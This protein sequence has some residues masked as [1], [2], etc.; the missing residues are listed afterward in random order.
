[1]FSH[2]KMITE[3]VTEKYIFV[4]ATYNIQMFIFSDY[5]FNYILITLLFMKVYMFH[6]TFS[7]YTERYTNDIVINENRVGCLAKRDIGY[8]VHDSISKNDFLL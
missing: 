4:L 6:I 2:T 3:Y 7:Y 5:I 1:M 8:F